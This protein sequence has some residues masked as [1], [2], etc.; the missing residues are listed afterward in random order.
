MKVKLSGNGLNGLPMGRK[1][2]KALARE[3]YP[4]K[5]GQYG[6]RGCRNL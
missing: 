2:S 3:V 1:V 6:T 5:S 4:K